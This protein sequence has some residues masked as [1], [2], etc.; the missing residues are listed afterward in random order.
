MPK[1]NDDDFALSLDNVLYRADDSG[2]VEPNRLRL[3]AL[4]AIIGHTQSKLSVSEVNEI[5]PINNTFD[6]NTIVDVISKLRQKAAPKYQYCVKTWGGFYNH[7]YFLI[8]GLKKGEY[9][10]DTLEERR[11]FIDERKTIS[12]HLNARELAI[13]CSEGFC[14][15]I[16]TVCHRV[17]EIDGT[18]YYSSFNKGRN[19]SFSDAKY[20]MEN[21]WYTG[22]NDCPLGG[23]FDYAA[24]DIKI[25]KE[26]IT[27]ADQELGI[28][29]LP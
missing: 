20:W 16:D 4:T 27:G 17:V 1:D 2:M 8:H 29:S 12:K 13:E 24:A 10:F 9:V 19:Y 23:D 21:K 25:I 22:F 6:F 7:E 14:C 26:W 15:N 5:I 28:N 18:Q 11:V 3:V